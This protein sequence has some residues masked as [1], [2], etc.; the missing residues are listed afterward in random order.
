MLS[1]FDFSNASS[2][3]LPA[4]TGASLVPPVVTT[5]SSS[6]QSSS[7]G[8]GSNYSTSTTASVTTPPTAYYGSDSGTDG[9]SS[10]MNDPDQAAQMRDAAVERAGQIVAAQ[11]GQPQFVSPQVFQPQVIQPQMIQP[12]VV[13]PQ[14]TQPQTAETQAPAEQHTEGPL[15]AALHD[16]ANFGQH[17]L[18][19]VLQP[20]AG[21]ADPVK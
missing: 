14:I 9:F 21:L 11:G 10:M 4:V 6:S 15:A 2:Q 20:L 1:S 8:N 12:Q 3:S 19:T 5:R 13:Q 7:A 16:V 18:Q 17:V